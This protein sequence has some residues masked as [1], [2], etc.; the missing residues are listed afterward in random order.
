MSTLVTRPDWISKRVKKDGFNLFFKDVTFAIGHLDQFTTDSSTDCFKAEELKIFKNALSLAQYFIVEDEAEIWFQLYS[1]LFQ[2]AKQNEIID[3]YLKYIV[4]NA[5]RTFLRF[6]EPFLLQASRGVDMLAVYDSPVSCISLSPDGKLVLAGSANGL[7][8]MG[9]IEDIFDTTTQWTGHESNVSCASLSEDCKYGVS[10]GS[11][12]S[13]VVFETKKNRRLLDIKKAHLSGVNDVAFSTNK[14]NT[15]F[16]CGSDGGICCWDFHLN[17]QTW[18]LNEAHG[19]KSVTGIFGLDVGMIVTGGEDG[20]IRFWNVSDSSEILERR[21]DCG[22]AILKLVRSANSRYL[23]ACLK[24]SCV[25]VWVVHKDWKLVQCFQ[26]SEDCA[27]ALDIS[28]SGALAIG[29]EAGVTLTYDVCEKECVGQMERIGNPL[30]C[31]GLIRKKEEMLCVGGYARGGVRVW[32]MRRK[33]KEINKGTTKAICLSPNEKDVVLAHEDGVIEVMDIISRTSRKSIQTKRCLNVLEMLKDGNRVAY[34]CDDGTV[35]IREI[36][37]D[38]LVGEWKEHD[39]AVLSI[40][41]SEDGKHMGS[42]GKDGVIRIRR[43]EY[44]DCP[45][46]LIESPEL[47]PL[48]SLFFGEE[49]TSVMVTVSDQEISLWKNY[50]VAKSLPLEEVTYCAG[51]YEAFQELGRQVLVRHRTMATL[52]NRLYIVDRGGKTT[53][54]GSYDID[55]LP[56]RW[57]FSTTTNTL[58]VVGDD[59]VLRFANLIENE[60]SNS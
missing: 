2:A 49:S 39:G 41:L 17:E 47:N 24:A 34:G 26:V 25:R 35:G 6:S 20:Y 37:N 52:R 48:Y 40:A 55:V 12:G 15:V 10:G 30:I 18:R 22:S 7:L 59:F 21:I 4:Q 57:N 58:C 53:R 8:S 44:L 16:S 13:L 19:G 56:S 51:R 29:T 5:P 28:P 23:A 32:D 36:W 33:E 42:S 14:S 38:T 46:L 54:V 31:L 43:L 60:G 50:G 9:A 1:R 45:S 3:R 27:S 11:N